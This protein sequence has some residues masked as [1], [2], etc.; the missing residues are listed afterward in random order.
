MGDHARAKAKKE[1]VKKKQEE[2]KAKAKAQERE[3]AAKRALEKKEK[4][5]EH[6]EKKETKAKEKTRKLDCKLK[7]LNREKEIKAAYPK[8]LSISYR[9][10]WKYRG[11]KHAPLAVYAK[12]NVCQLEG[13]LRKTKD[14]SIVAKLNDH[15]CRPSQTLYFPANHGNRQVAIQI[16]KAGFV[17]IGDY[18]PSYISLSGLVWS[19]GNYMLMEEST[20][21][22]ETRESDTTGASR[23]QAKSDNSRWSGAIKE[24]N[25]WRQ[26]KTLAAHKHGNLCILA[27]Q[28]EGDTWLKPSR[29]VQGTRYVAKLP[30][31]CR[32]YQRLMFT[33]YGMPTGEPLRVDVLPDGHIEVIDV[34]NRPLEPKVNLYGIVFS[35]VEGKHIKLNT[36]FDSYGHGYMSPQARQE[37]GMCHVQGLVKGSVSPRKV[38]TLPSWCRPAKTLTF[39]GS[40][41]RHLHRL[42]VMPNG[43]VMLKPG[44]NG[45]DSLHGDKGTK[46]WKGTS[47]V[48]LSQ[49]TFPIP[50]ESAYGAIMNKPCT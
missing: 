39:S 21:L 45:G 38:G 6:S 43:D 31:D 29:D 10:G 50:Y 28:L 33:T 20:E 15:R 40:N 7:K 44:A 25:G 47:F 48:S 34:H 24:M 9:G 46:G 16:D 1:K 5:K 35:T 8:K 49:I 32:P 2:L 19:R 30:T 18:K 13:M 12:G 22:L 14:S 27:G 4:A 11:G 36:G 17:R 37:N 41:N 23:R 3:L 42:D 26:K